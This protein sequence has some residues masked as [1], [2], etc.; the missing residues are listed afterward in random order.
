M[1]K[2]NIPPCASAQPSPA[3][4]LWIDQLRGLHLR[5]PK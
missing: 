1:V 5:A 3:S 4:D 2:A